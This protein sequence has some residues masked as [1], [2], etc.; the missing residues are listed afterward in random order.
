M[1][2]LLEIFVEFGVENLA[3]NLRIYIL[4]MSCILSYRPNELWWGEKK[5][6]FYFL[7][8]DLK[9]KTNS[10]INV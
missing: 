8:A 5:S 7:D 9:A 2:S 1:T 6:A 3:Q 4:K 10:L